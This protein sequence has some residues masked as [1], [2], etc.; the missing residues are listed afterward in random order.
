VERLHDREKVGIPL[1][2]ALL[3][4]SKQAYYKRLH[5]AEKAALEDELILRHVL[6]IRKEQP[7]LGGR[8]L[9][10][11][12]GKL[13]PAGLLPGRDAFFKLLE[14]N[15]LLIRRRKVPKPTT[16][17]SWHHYHKYGNL[18]KGRI[19]GRPNEVW[20]TDITYLRLE[21]GGFLYLS[22]ITDA[23]SHKVVGWH[24][25]DSLCMDGPLEA[26]RIALPRLG[27]GHSLTHHSDR[28]VQYCSHAYVALL[29]AHGIS[30]SMTENGDPRENA[31]AE[32][33][34]G[35][36]KEEWLNREAISSLAHGR[37]L[38]DKAIAI[39]NDKRP[40][41]SIDYLTPSEADQQEGE[42]RRRWRA[43]YKKKED[44]TTI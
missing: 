42:L 14:L 9:Y 29:Q 12:L 38:V 41:M 10:H 35:I 18:Y 23:Y 6:E 21:D 19:P 37:A 13:L 2:C 31:V 44:I 40:H 25:S 36:L 26:L 7:V 32:R 17:L 1:C 43:S 16:T 28:G 34:N 4:R 24:L 33:V 3:G 22:L 27:Q 30:I 8:K 11:L 15:G 5:A 20:V 39:Y